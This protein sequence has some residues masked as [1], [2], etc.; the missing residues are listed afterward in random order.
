MGWITTRLIIINLTILVKY[1]SLPCISDPLEDTRFRKP[2]RII[3]EA[4]FFIKDYSL[5][6]NVTTSMLYSGFP[7]ELFIN[8]L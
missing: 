1:Y 3:I 6:K 2:E 5:N 4:H 7:K 8:A